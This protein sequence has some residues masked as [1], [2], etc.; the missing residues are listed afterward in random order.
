GGLKHLTESPCWSTLQ[1]LDLSH[2]P[3][4]ATGAWVLAEAEPPARLHTLRLADCDFD[5]EAGKALSTIPWL[6]NLLALDLSG[7]A[8]ELSHATDLEKLA[9]GSLRQL[10]LAGTYVNADAM[11]QLAPCLARL[12]VLDLSNTLI[13]DHGLEELLLRNSAPELQSLRLCNSQLTP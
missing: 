11:T 3:L 5:L 1:R 13:G 8:L 12:I 7:N 10:S 4:G 9:S 2:N 6:P